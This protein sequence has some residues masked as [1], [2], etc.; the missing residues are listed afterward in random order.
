[1]LSPVKWGAGG[2]PWWGQRGQLVAWFYQNQNEIYI[3]MICI[4]IKMRMVLKCCKS[5]SICMI[6]L[7]Y[8]KIYD[9]PDLYQNQN[10]NG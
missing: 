8:I 2:Q 9:K 3:K 5:L 10:E 7:I 4:K 1:M 6:T